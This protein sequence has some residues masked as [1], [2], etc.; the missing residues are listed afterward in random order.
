MTFRVALVGM[1]GGYFGERNPGCFLILEAAL[2]ALER[3]LPDTTFDIYSEDAIYRF[4]G[5]RSE[6]ADSGEG[7]Q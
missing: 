2:R 7:G 4:S 5:I 6:V 3:R 1:Y